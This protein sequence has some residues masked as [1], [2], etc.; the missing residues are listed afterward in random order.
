MSDVAKPARRGR[1][2]VEDEADERAPAPAQEPEDSQD[3]QAQEGGERRED[4]GGG[5]N[6]GRTTLSSEIRGAIRDSAIEVLKPVARQATTAAAKFAVKKGPDLVKD[7]VIPKVEEAGGAGGLAKGVL[8]KGG[9][10]AGGVGQ[11]ASGI[12]EKVTGK[13]GKGGGKKPTGHGR[14]RRLPVQEFV[15][16]AADIQTVYDQFTQFEDFPNFMHRVEKVEQRDDTTLMWHENIWGVRRSWEAEIVEQKPCERMVW[17]SKGPLQTVGVVTFHRLSDNLTRVYMN[18]DFQPKGLF[19]KTASGFRLSRRALRSDLMRFKAFVE[20]RDDATG[21][22]RG[23]V[24]EGEV[25]EGPDEAEGREDEGAEGRED[26]RAEGRED[27]RAEGREESDEEE[28][29]GEGDERQQPQA[30]SHEEEEEQEDKGEEREE[31]QAESDEEEDEGDEREQPQAES[32]E[33]EE[34]EERDEPQATKSDRDQEEEEDEEEYVDEE[35]EEPQAAEDEEQPA[36]EEEEEERPARREP[37]RG[38]ARSGSSTTSRRPA[39]SGSR[40]S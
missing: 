29:E 14:G 6:G 30:E 32:D 17:R 33:H 4:D 20:M 5:G 27:E 28:E 2:R 35:P 40:S 8:S 39:R 13:G 9:G 16:V 36:G 25:V 31:P 38:R 22:W 12:A 1:R 23:K 7:K 34:D 19:E 24:E 10:A 3:E 11:F 37:A 18:N 26:E 15:D 21:A